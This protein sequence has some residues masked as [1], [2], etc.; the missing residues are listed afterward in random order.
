MNRLPAETPKT[1]LT[2]PL[3]P[4]DSSELLADSLKDKISVYQTDIGY[5]LVKC[6]ECG[7]CVPLMFMSTLIKHYIGR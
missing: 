2:N 7:E 5:K 3:K 4:T 6:K 1:V